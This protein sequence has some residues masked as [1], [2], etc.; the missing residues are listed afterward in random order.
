MDQLEQLK[1]ENQ[2]IELEKQNILETSEL[3]KQKILETSK[4]EKQKILE[5]SE[6]EAKNYMPEEMFKKFKEKLKI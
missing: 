5:T 2:K 3:E 4:L 1:L 6:E